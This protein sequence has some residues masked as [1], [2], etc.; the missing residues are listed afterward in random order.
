MQAAKL[1]RRGLGLLSGAR[2][3][4]SSVAGGAAFSGLVALCLLAVGSAAWALDAGKPAPDVTGQDVSGKPVSLSSLRGKVVIVDFMA[5]WCGPCKAELPVLNKLYL[6]HRESGLV[7]LGVS[8]DEKSENL[9]KF[10]KDV[11]VS[12]S[13]LHDVG[14]KAASKYAPSRMPSSF[15]VDKQGMVRYVHGG[16]TAGDEKTIEHEVL[17]LLR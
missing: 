9:A 8:V 11:P 12:F 2:L 16:F 1:E 15:I 10:L 13:V 17:E 4:I 6:K 5:S 14:H 3:R 7:V